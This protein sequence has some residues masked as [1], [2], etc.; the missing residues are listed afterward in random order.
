M[1]KIQKSNGGNYLEQRSQKKTPFLMII[2]TGFLLCLSINLVSAQMEWDNVINYEKDDKI[3]VFDNALGFG[4]TIARAELTTPIENNY[5]MPG[6]NR[7]VMIYNIENYGEEYI[8]GLEDVEITNMRTGE[9][10][11]KEF[12]YEFAVYVEKETPIYKTSC[13]DKELV[14][15]SIETTCSREQIR[16]EIG[17]V[18]SEW[19]DLTDT[20]V[21]SGNITIALVT[22]VEPGDY[23]DGVF[24]LFGKKVSKHGTWL[25]SFNEGLVSYYRLDET[26]S[27]INVEDIVHGLN[28]GTTYLGDTNWTTDGL[29]NGAKYQIKIADSPAINITQINETYDTM[30]NGVNNFSIGGWIRSNQ[31]GVFEYIFG[32]ARNTIMEVVKDTSDNLIMDVT[33]FS[34]GGDP[35]ELTEGEWR[36]IAVV[37][38]HNG[39]GV[40]T[41]MNMTTFVNGTIDSSFI[42]EPQ[43]GLGRETFIGQRSDLGGS[44]FNGS[45]DEWAFWNR[46]LSDSEV[47]DLFNDGNGITYIADAPTGTP[48]I[49]LNEPEN[50]FNSTVSSITFNCSVTISGGDQIDNLTLYHNATGTWHANETYD[51]SGL[52]QD[53]IS[54]EFNLEFN[55]VGFIWNCLAVSNLSAQDFAPTNFS[56]NVDTTFPQVN[57]SAPVNEDYGFIK[58][59][60]TLNWSASDTMGLSDCWYEYNSTNTSVTCSDTNVTF[61]IA[62]ALQNNQSLIFYANDTFNQINA[63][64]YSW[65]YSIFRNGNETYNSTVYE[66]GVQHYMINVTTNSSLT[67]ANLIWDGISYAGTQSG[68]TWSRTLQIPNGTGVGKEFYW[69]FD[70]DLRTINSSTITFNHNETN[71]SLCGDNGGTTPFINFTF[72]DEGSS[73]AIPNATI[74]ASSWTYWLASGDG[75]VNKTYSFV[76]ATGN[77]SYAFCALPNQSLTI[78][79]SLQYEDSD[80]TYPQRTYENL[81]IINNTVTNRLLYLLNVADGIYVTFQVINVAE[82]PLEGVHVNATR[83]I[84]GSTVT[85][86]EGD[87]GADGGV[88]FWLNPNFLHTLTFDSFGRDLFITTITPTQSS[89]TITLGEIIGETENDYTE[90]IDFTINPQNTTVFNDTTYAFQFILTSNFWE[91]TE[92]GLELFNSSSDS[93]G[94]NRVSTNGGTSTLNYNVGNT[95]TYIQMNYY[96]VIEGNYSNGTRN[97]YIMSDTGTDW[98]IRTFFDDFKT[99]S[100]T[101]MFGLDEFGKAII[102]FLIVFVFVGIMSFRFGL[103]SPA[104]IASLTFGLVLFFDIGLDLMSGFTPI[105]A[106]PHFPTIFMG[107]IM[108]G[109]L[110][111]E[112]I[113]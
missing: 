106:V 45:L 35:A 12:H 36:H 51:S 97:W 18:I 43:A 108:A 60:R 40:G 57:I 74:P 59:N 21:P 113:R 25:S 17:M 102:V 5:V 2:L 73:S 50:T 38:F 31:T 76:N 67:G 9:K 46:T 58:M 55:D 100:D 79:Y 77:P 88:T 99:Y 78:D 61:L 95:S 70:Y 94:S 80:G 52:A 3:A 103:V 39:S 32:H 63:T 44:S 112:V 10:I 110:L 20:N 28:N 66:T 89:Y 11:N 47:S 16:T 15:K 23:Y 27:T 72:A 85:V 7:R 49:T 30:F 81:E 29:I 84:G 6:K 54:R 107:I 34:A 109:I 22:D 98:S 69:S 37:V 48:V 4:A 41:G 62:G 83:E 75:T 1:E 105:D 92:F 8:D 91:V 82:Q 90:G 64:Y 101:G 13:S 19:K 104:G 42:W 56:V 68:E 26:G 53:N 33:G 86:G 14:N 96:W 65:N 111:K 93:V 24:I 71:F 87:T